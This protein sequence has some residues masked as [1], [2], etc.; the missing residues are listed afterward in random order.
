M[1]HVHP[2]RPMRPAESLGS[3]QKWM[4]LLL[5]VPS[6]W[7]RASTS[8]R[9]QLLLATVAIVTS[10]LAS[11]AR[12]ADSTGADR[13]IAIAIP[14]PEI[15]TAANRIGNSIQRVCAPQP[16]AQI[17]RWEVEGW[18]P[19]QRLWNEFAANPGDPVLRKYLG[20]PI[21]TTAR[22]QS[23]LIKSSR[24]RSAPSWLGWK[25]GTYQQVD[26]PHLQIFSH[27]DDDATREVAADLERVY[28]VWTQ[29]FFPLWES[30]GQV[31]LQL[32]NVAENQTIASSLSKNPARLSS[33]RKLRIVLL[34]DAADY[35]RTLGQSMPG[36][37]QSTGFYSDERQTSFF[38]PS[39]SADAVA[40]RRHEL[41]HQLF[42]EATR[43]GLSG[44]SPGSKL[45]FWLVEGIAGYF[46]SLQF[47]QNGATVGGWDSPRLQFA[48]YRTLGGRDFI[49]L[50]ELRFGG[51]ETV[52]KQADLA[53]WYANAIAYTHALLDGDSIGERRW[54]YQLLA[55]LY[56][57]RVDVP[58][59]A[60][61]SDA[62][63][64]LV[65][66]LKIDDT[67]IRSNPT[68]R[69]LGELCLSG[70]EVTARGLAEIKTDQHCR[71]IDLSRLP[72][73]VQDVT[74]L[75]PDPTG[76]D[77]LSLEVTRIDHS[78]SD[79]LRLAK[80]LHELDLS[81]TDC[82]DETIASISDHS[83]IQT[84]WMTG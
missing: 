22:Q 29:L 78:I 11:L 37:G 68:E 63:R 75:C 26:T 55:S 21:G 81:W 60:T 57:I 79:W 30:Q 71:W 82:G 38:Y 64:K 77:Q 52:Q 46:E 65:D 31:A 56:Q 24:G 17:P 72:I 28:W 62:E 84:L 54:V 13:M 41:V 49:P 53:R 19:Y 45:D 47:D 35:V 70:C 20:L 14:G 3:P 7:M 76:L 5:S 10:V 15:Q 32:A 2:S 43:S 33:R 9:F 42:R 69:K 80:N 25:S 16:D 39:D 36:I 34:K 83:K 18:E 44:D 40:T 66:F 50:E 59:A 8:K 61:P 4:T 6:H 1:K 74:K 27:A 51:R 48:R 12:S 73:T 67:V 58:G 23:V